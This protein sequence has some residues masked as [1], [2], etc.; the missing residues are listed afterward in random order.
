MRKSLTTA[1]LRAILVAADT[2]SFDR[3]ADR[4][5]TNVSQGSR[6]P[7]RKV[8]YGFAFYTGGERQ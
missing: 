6:S 5:P 4:D 7:R 2:P 8:L 1:T 3:L